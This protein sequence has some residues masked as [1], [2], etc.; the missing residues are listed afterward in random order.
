MAPTHGT[1]SATA[2]EPVLTRLVNQDLV[3]WYRK[4]NLRVLYMLLLP[5]CIGIEMT[6]GFD[7][8]MI[9]TVQISDFWQACAYCE[10]LPFFFAD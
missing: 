6:S 10:W 7:S 1:A 9:N 3:P 8:Q 4:P 5:T 2:A